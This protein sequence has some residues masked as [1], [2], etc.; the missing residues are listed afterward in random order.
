MRTAETIKSEIDELSR[1]IDNHSYT[2][3]QSIEVLREQIIRRKTL[4]WV[5]QNE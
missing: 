3:D 5:L 2:N 4:R 1:K